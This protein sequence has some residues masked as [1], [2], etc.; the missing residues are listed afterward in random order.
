MGNALFPHLFKVMYNSL[1]DRQNKAT[2]EGGANIYV[3]KAAD[4]LWNDVFLTQTTQ[5]SSSV[6]V[7]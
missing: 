3:P 2:E 4:V 1:A 7:E 5:F 6:F